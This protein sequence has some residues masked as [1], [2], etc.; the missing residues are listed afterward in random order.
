[1]QKYDVF[2]L[3]TEFETREYLEFQTMLLHNGLAFPG[4][5]QGI[6]PLE[7]PENI[8]DYKVLVYFGRDKH[9]LSAGITARRLKSFRDNG[10]YVIEVPYEWNP[11]HG[12]IGVHPYLQPFILDLLADNAVSI[13]HISDQTRQVCDELSARD[14]K[15]VFSE[16][17]DNLLGPCAHYYTEWGDSTVNYLHSLLYAYK[18]EPNIKIKERAIEIIS[19]LFSNYDAFCECS[20]SLGQLHPI[21]V[22]AEICDVGWLDID[23]NKLL[24]KAQLY[25]SRSY[26][27]K[28]VLM[29]ESGASYDVCG[30]HAQLVPT[31]C[32][33]ANK[34]GVPE[35]FDMAI[36]SLAAMEDVLRD[37]QDDLW[38][39]AFVP[40]G[41]TPVKWGR[42]MAWSVI[43]ASRSLVHIPKTHP[44]R[45]VVLDILSRQL[46]ALAKVQTEY[47]FW[48][49]ILDMPISRNESSCTAFFLEALAVAAA[50]GIEDVVLSQCRKRAHN[51]IKSMI[52]KGSVFSNCCGTG[53]S[54]SG[55]GY[56]LRRKFELA[57]ATY[58]MIGLTLNLLYQKGELE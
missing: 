4:I 57:P 26:Y 6:L 5:S 28:G 18:L 12:F 39:H 15:I 38:Y 34:C 25:L 1:M 52:W 31:L 44:K 29:I 53:I 22:M 36:D 40:A 58:A 49:N 55:Y 13:K 7:L 32:A 10:G 43:G 20:G 46:H 41:R 33:L 42:G 16:M 9:R 37:P 54:D 27:N 56:Y 14:D 23:F 24:S 2:V 19:H 50:N 11:G 17:V 45:K 48:K 8:E 51:G 47:G 3:G 21:A 35:L 30:E